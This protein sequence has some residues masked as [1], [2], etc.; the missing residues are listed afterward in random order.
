[1]L[2]FLPRLD[3]SSPWPCSEAADMQLLELL[4]P[5]LQRWRIGYTAAPALCQPQFPVIGGIPQYPSG[6]TLWP[7]DW[8]H[9]KCQTACKNKPR[10]QLFPCPSGRQPWCT[11]LLHNT[12][13]GAH[14]GR[15]AH[16]LT[17]VWRN[18]Q[19]RREPIPIFQVPMKMVIISGS[20]CSECLF[21]ICCR[22]WQ[23][24]SLF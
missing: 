22:S 19:V 12:A 20:G 21:F 9:E 23:N 15:W 14:H 11:D 1:M 4:L 2:N 17:S 8:N 10:D 5:F 24:P 6:P 16:I 3:V 13:S 18:A 7:F